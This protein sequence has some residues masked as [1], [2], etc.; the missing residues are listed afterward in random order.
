MVITMWEDGNHLVG[1]WSLTC[2]E[3]VITTWGYGHYYVGI[4]SLP[5]GDSV[6]TCIQYNILVNSGKSA[7]TVACK[8]GKQLVNKSQSTANYHC[9]NNMVITMWGY[10][11]YHAGRW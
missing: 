11:H 1:I 2:G 9:L 7:S 5:C 3:M 6:D 8:S 4:W 10:G